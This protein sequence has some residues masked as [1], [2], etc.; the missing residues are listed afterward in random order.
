M[1]SIHSDSA[2]GMVVVHVTFLPGARTHWHT[3]ERGQVLQVIQGSGWVCDKGETP[4]RIRVGDTVVCPPGT[5][6]W[7]GADEGSLMT[8]TAIGLG[9]TEWLEGVTDEDYNKIKSV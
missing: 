3:H 8:H 1:N 4:R 9:K 7:H 6:H 5:H 2:A